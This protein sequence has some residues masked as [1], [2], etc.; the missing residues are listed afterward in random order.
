MVYLSSSPRDAVRAQSIL[1]GWNIRIHCAADLSEALL[2]LEVVGA[3]VLMVD[4]IFTGG[5]WSDALLAASTHCPDTAVIV[6]VPTR[7]ALAWEDIIPAGG[8]DVVLKPFTPEEIGPVVENANQYARELRS[9]R[10]ARKKK[11][12]SP[13]P[14][15]ASWSM[16]HPGQETGVHGGSGKPGR[17]IAHRAFLLFRNGWSFL[18]RPFHRRAVP[19]RQQ[20]G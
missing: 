9:D 16:H 6:A 3:K 4:Y 10:A 14:D 20:G 2:L 18:K 19:R 7:L 11:V 12:L 1:A 17:G 13:T 15:Q 8:Y 5:S